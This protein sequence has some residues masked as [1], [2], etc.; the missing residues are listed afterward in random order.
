[1]TN[2]TGSRSF[3]SCNRRMVCTIFYLQRASIHSSNDTASPIA[4]ARFSS[5]H[6]SRERAVCNRYVP[7]RL[8]D[9]A[10]DKAAVRSGY[11]TLDL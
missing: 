10:A 2:N 7:L 6:T 11:R 1:M 4:R 9:N 8:T 5:G 3:F